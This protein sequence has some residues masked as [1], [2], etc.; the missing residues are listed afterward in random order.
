[1]DAFA[2]GSISVTP[3][4]VQQLDRSEEPLSQALHR[5]RPER[6]TMTYLILG[7]GTMTTNLI[8]LIMRD[9]TCV[10]REPAHDLSQ[11]TGSSS[12]WESTIATCACELRPLSNSI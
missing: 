6:Y 2:R 9:L 12:V 11:S 1:M 8:H 5:L 4:W 3:V 10:E 7:S